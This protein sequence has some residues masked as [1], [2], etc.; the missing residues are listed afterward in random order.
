M[1]S[2][3]NK[4][5]RSSPIYDRERQRARLLALCEEIDTD[6]RGYIATMTFA[7]L[8][9]GMQNLRSEITGHQSGSPRIEDPSIR[10]SPAKLAPS[11]STL[12]FYKGN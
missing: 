7:K 2:V 12:S 8:L 11:A 10:D 5:F 9:K 4:N 1:S 3:E 6:G